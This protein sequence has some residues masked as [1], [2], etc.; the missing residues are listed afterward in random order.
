MV[1]VPRTGIGEEEQQKNNL[2]GKRAT[3]GRLKEEKLC[4][5]FH[6]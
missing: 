6:S 5:K 4:Q 2:E 1:A 3:V